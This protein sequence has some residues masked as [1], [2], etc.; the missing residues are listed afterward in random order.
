LQLPHRFSCLLLWAQL[1]LLGLLS[2]NRTYAAQLELA[3]LIVIVPLV[4]GAL[5]ITSPVL[6]ENAISW[7]P[8]VL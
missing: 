4:F 5:T 2:V 3:R 1:Y 6:L 7:S 8:V